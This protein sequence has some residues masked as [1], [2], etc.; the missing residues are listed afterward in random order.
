MTAAGMI[1][2]ESILKKEGPEYRMIQ[3]H[4]FQ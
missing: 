2:F 4:P 3:A 1:L